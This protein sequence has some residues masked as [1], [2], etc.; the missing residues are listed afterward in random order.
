MKFNRTKYQKKINSYY[1]VMTT[2]LDGNSTTLICKDAENARKKW[3]SSYNPASDNKLSSEAHK[4]MISSTKGFHKHIGTNENS[5]IILYTSG[6]SESNSTIYRS[7]V[8]SYTFIVKKKPHIITSLVEHHS[9]MKC[10]SILERKNLCSVTYIKPNIYGNISSVQVEDEIKKNKNTALVSIIYANNELG[11]INSISL[12]SQVCKKYDI[13]LHT[14]A[15][16]MFGKCRLNVTKLGVTS[17]SVSFHKFYGPKSFGLLILNKQFVDGYKLDGIIHGSQ[18]FGLRGGT[19]DVSLIASAYAALNFTFKKR[20][21]K[22]AHLFKLKERLVKTLSD[23]FP[24]VED[25]KDYLSGNI[26]SAKKHK[27]YIL[28]LGP[29]YKLKERVLINT[30]M[31]CIIPF[32]SEK[33]CNVKLKKKLADANIFVSITSACLTSLSHASHVLH[34]IDADEKIKRGVLRVS[35]I[36]N[37][38]VKDI[39]YFTNKLFSLLQRNDIFKD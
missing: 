6:A 2:Y 19:Q 20:N 39:T 27:F 9:T 4:V 11:T 24:V 5:H 29:K 30:L 17:M 34:A 25:Y 37:T 14:D 38:K 32:G 13:P 26:P 22:N 23:K 21:E 12:I 10:L 31:I 18:Q 3:S 7:V 15:V 28:L 16:Q 8:E 33:L 36:D 35:F 1:I